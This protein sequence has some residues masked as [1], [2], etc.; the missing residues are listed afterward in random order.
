MDDVANKN[1]VL[2]SKSPRRQNLFSAISSNFEIIT[3]EVEE[4]YPS[5]LNYADVPVFLSELKAQ[6]FDTERNQTDQIF[7][8]ADT[9][10]AFDNK[11][12]G[13]PKNESEATK[14]LQKLSNNFHEVIT[15]VTI[16]QQNRQHSFAVTSKVH[17]DFLS[18]E[19]IKEYVTREQPLDK[20]GSYGIQESIGMIGISKIEGC[21]YNIMGLP[22]NALYNELKKFIRR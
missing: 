10:V 7:I 14:M 3:K 22:V 9:I 19:R 6:A 12:L 2:A 20:A 5:E 1:Y 21:Y 4:S 17:F 15:G 13:K 18:E 11:V 8:T 16:S